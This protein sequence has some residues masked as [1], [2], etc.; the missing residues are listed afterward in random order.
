MRNRTALRLCVGLLA[1]L[2][3]TPAS[4]QYRPRPVA[5]A[6]LAERYKIEAT[7][8]LWNPSPEMW[9][10]SESLGIIGSRIDFVDD[11]GLAKKRLG[12]LG[13][14]FHPGRKH[15]L[16]FE[17]L[18]IVYT[19]EATLARDIVFNGQR[20]RTGVAVD[21]SL[22]WKAY[23][24]SYEFDFISM[25]RGFGGLIVDM[26]VT[27]IKATLQTSVLDEFTKLRAPVPT[28]GG[29]ARV[30][31]VPAVSVTGELTGIKIPKRDLYDFNGH[32]ADLSIYGTVNVHKNVGAQIGYRSFD[33]EATIDQD[34]GGFTMKGLYFGIVA[35]Y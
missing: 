16:R 15:K 29:I 25:S 6:P 9:I 26:R 14:T 5:D 18:P 23:R 35:R 13:V 12:A 22:D 3:A 17:Y 33:V 8:G 10:T 7:A 1:L 21:S 27:D 20:Y 34:S 32:Y 19:Q 28:L 11:L 4:A 31:I 2:M 30:Y 24:F